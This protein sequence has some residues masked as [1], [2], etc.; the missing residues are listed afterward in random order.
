MLDIITIGSA[1]HDVFLSSKHFQVDHLPLGSKIEIE[2]FHNASGGAG[3]NTAVTFARQG[4]MVACIGV[5]GDDLEG[6]EIERDLANEGVSIEYLLKHNDAHTAYS[7][8]LVD[9]SGERT[10]LGYKGEGQHFSKVNIP[11]AKMQAHWFYLSS[12]GGDL[13]ILTAAVQA[14]R[15]CGAKIAFNPGTKEL[16]HGLEGLK[17]AFEQ[18]DILFLNRDEGAALTGVA[19]HDWEGIAKALKAVTKG[20]VSVSDGHK[21]VLVVDAEGALYQAGVPDSPVIERTGAGDAFGSG[22]VAE[23]MKSNTIEKAIQFGTANASSVVTKYGAK[24]GILKKDNNG[25]WPLVDVK[26]L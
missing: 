8:I 22:F 5:V 9:P 6:K 7:V 10:I 26:R 2:E 25:P 3:T 24:E 20:V 11:W 4:H 15:G 18:T 23:Y 12:L 17:V 19:L 16:A 13:S 21:G 1:T 14:A